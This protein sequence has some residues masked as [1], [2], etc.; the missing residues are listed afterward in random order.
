MYAIKMPDIGFYW[1][2]E[3]NVWVDGKNL[4]IFSLTEALK[5][6]I[7]AHQAGDL[8]TAEK[9]YSAILST[10]PDHPDANH[11]LAIIAMER[12]QKKQA[13][14]LLTKTCEI[15]LAP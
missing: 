6:G 14:Q 1:M 13:I 2:T 12:G 15:V 7:S 10:L 11:N 9:F 5:R 4:A 8:V 3:K